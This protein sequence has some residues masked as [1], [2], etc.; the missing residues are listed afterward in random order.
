MIDLHIH[1]T[2]SADGQHSPDEIF[3]M[4]A[5]IGLRA[6][7]F[8]DHNSIRSVSRGIEL[9]A[10][11]EIR[12]LP[13]V[14]LNTG[15]NSRDL[16]LLVYGFDPN[17]ARIASLIADV[18][19]GMERQVAMR[20]EKFA[21]LGLVLKRSELNPFSKSG[22][23]TGSSFLKALIEHVDYRSHPLI[24][25]YLPG[26]ARSESPFVNFYQEV[27][28]DGPIS[29]P[30][31]GPSTIEAIRRCREMPAAPVLAHPHKLADRVIESLAESGLVGLEVFSSYHEPDDIRRHAKNA[32]KYGLAI[33]A[34][35]DFHGKLFKPDVDL[36]CIGEADF[37]LFEK[38]LERIRSLR[39]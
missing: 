19:E 34:G 20:L 10:E 3:A 24:S 31:Q 36:G 30:I 16:H 28:R 8:A 6:I 11:S 38:L 17:D 35:S 39:S 7:A 2:S 25:P 14:E 4:A 29:V 32:G 26:G 27:L 22:F 21:A 23:P 9:S 5:E 12:F 37:S 15:F 33:T 13:A 1:T 18:L